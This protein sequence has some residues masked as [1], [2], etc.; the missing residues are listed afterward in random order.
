M[1]RPSARD[2]GDFRKPPRRNLSVIEATVERHRR[3]PIPLPD[4]NCGDSGGD[5]D[6]TSTISTGY[7]DGDIDTN[8]SNNADLQ[9]LIAQRYSRRQ[10]LFGGL[11]AISAAALSMTLAGCGD[12]ESEDRPSDTIVSLGGQGQSSSGKV[13]TLSG[14]T[15]R[16]PSGSTTQIT[17]ISGPPVTLINAKTPTASFIAPSVATS[18]PLLFRLTS[19]DPRGRQSSG[20]FVVSIDPAKLD[21]AAVP[22]NL[23]DIVTVPAG[24]TATVLYRLGDP[25]NAATP[26]YANNGGEAGFSGRAGDHHDALYYYGL[27]DAGNGRDDSNNRRGLLVMN[28][29]NITQVYLHPNG[30]TGTAAG[31]TRP[32]TEALKEME[33]H[34]VSVVEVTRAGDSGAWSYVQAGALNRRITPLTPMAINGPVRGSGLVRTAYSPDGSGGRGTIN[35][36]ANGYT[37]WGTNLTCEENWA[38]YFRR[39][40]STDNPRRSAKE[41]TGF[42]RYG[43]TSSTGNYG[44]AGVAAADSGTTIYRRWNAVVDPAASGPQADFRNEANQ[45]GWVVEIDPYDPS[46]APRKR[47]ALGR[48]NHEGAWPGNFVAGRRPA[49]YM[50]DDARGDYVQVRLVRAVGARRCAIGQSPGDR[51]QISR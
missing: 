8:R 16:A 27:S 25:L 31:Q 6:S 18:T 29:E 14:T 40:T 10:T 34:G 9:S 32:E 44:W 38:G 41:V 30:P 12:D 24:Y 47:T 46:A 5:M 7:S 2:T 15:E 26:A 28:H 13:V 11:G 33:A 1:P 4:A 17:Q 23:N 39:P 35:N 20:D 43:V 21:F 22:K 45:F 49:F 42:A 3:L 50:G 48:F 36:C 19:T 51:G 37:P